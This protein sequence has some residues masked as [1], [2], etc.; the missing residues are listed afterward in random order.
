MLSCVFNGGNVQPSTFAPFLVQLFLVGDFSCWFSTVFRKRCHTA[1]AKPDLVN[2]MFSIHL[3]RLICQ[4]FNSFFKLV[5][6]YSS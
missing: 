4:G 2:V 3:R 6:G 1:C 5:V